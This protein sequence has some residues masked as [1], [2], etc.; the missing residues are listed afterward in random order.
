MIY[1]TVVEIVDDK[2]MSAHA[3]QPLDEAVE[4]AY[5]MVTEN[6]P[7]AGDDSIEIYR[8]LNEYKNYHI[9]AWSVYVLETVGYQS[10]HELL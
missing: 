10:L 8:Q 7:P 4:L 2:P 3:P 1:Y 9:G 5:H 6:D